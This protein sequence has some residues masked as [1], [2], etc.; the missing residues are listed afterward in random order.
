V[1]FAAAGPRV[2]GGSELL[3][4]VVLCWTQGARGQFLGE[5]GSRER[6]GKEKVLRVLVSPT[7]RQILVGV[8][9]PND[10]SMGIGSSTA[11]KSTYICL[12]VLSISSLILR[13]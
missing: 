13:A 2:E 3:P 9:V 4:G 8:K 7:C 11:Y 12:H 5:E 6:G 1:S 10:C